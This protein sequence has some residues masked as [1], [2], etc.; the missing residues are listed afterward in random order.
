MEREKN[1]VNSTLYLA[2]KGQEFIAIEGVND[3]CFTGV[4]S[5]F[6][7]VFYIHHNNADYNE[8]DQKEC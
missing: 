7:W 5:D 6:L 2:H 1:I 4:N 8:K 3:E